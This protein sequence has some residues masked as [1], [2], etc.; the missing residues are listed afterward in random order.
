ALQDRHGIDVN[1][2]LF[3]CWAGASGYGTL[4]EDD[5][6]RALAVARPWQEE[7]IA[8]LRQVRERLKA[9]SPEAPEKTAEAVRQRVAAAEIDAE[10]VEQ[11]MIAAM[12]TRAPGAERSSADDLG[13]AAVNLDRY[14]SAVADLGDV[15]DAA[16]LADLAAV[17][18]GAF[19]TVDRAAVEA[20]LAATLC[21][22]A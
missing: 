19:P 21:G 16:D 12:L 22:G 1:M 18:A 8:P 10:H 4:D 2:L 13:D 17:L 5:F 11:L 3:C 15:A 14:L 9:A 6:S 20:R 7:I